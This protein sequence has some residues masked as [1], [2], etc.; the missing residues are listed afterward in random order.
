MEMKIDVEVIDHR[1]IGK[2]HDGKIRPIQVD[3]KDEKTK[4]YVISKGKL[5]RA[6]AEF[7][8]V[9]ISPDLTES[10]RKVELELREKLKKVREDEKNGEGRLWIIRKGKIVLKEN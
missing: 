5:L 1:R 8:R 2:K 6:T 3:V 7:S 9:Y 10:E 4:W